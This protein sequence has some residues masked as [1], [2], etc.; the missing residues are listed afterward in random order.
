LKGHQ[1]AILS[2]AFAPDGFHVASAG[3]ST[4]RLAATSLLSQEGA[5][6]ALGGSGDVRM[7]DLNHPDQTAVSFKG[8]QD[9]V[10]A[11][12]FSP[13]SSRL[14]SAGADG[15]VR[16]F[17]PKD[18][19]RTSVILNERRLIEAR[20]QYKTMLL[21]RV[22]RLGVGNDEAVQLQK[23]IAAIGKGHSS[24]FTV[25]LSSDLQW[26]ATVGIERRIVRLWNLKNPED[27]PLVLEGRVSNL[28]AL[29]FSPDATRLASV[30]T[31]IDTTVQVWD[32][33]HPG[34]PRVSG[35]QGTATAVAFS[36]DSTR[37]ALGSFS[38]QSVTVKL[39]D[40]KATE[41]PLSLR[42]QGSRAID[43][44]AFSNDGSRVAGL[45]RSTGRVVIWN[46]WSRTADYLCT[47]VWRNLSIDEW[48]LYVGESIPYERTCPA[49]PSGP[50]VDRK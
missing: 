6:L 23:A 38:G 11:V 17:S 37:L 29:A 41:P 18:P 7:W 28:T 49:L 25:A 44:L 12:G 3:S 9:A 16:E 32:L 15:T 35:T 33:R 46:L 1:D 21:D 47:R 19:G 24:F 22:R 5:R 42:G 48:R 20:E 34:A 10:I 2:V 40:L 45:E 36:P 31:G 13:D 50:G 27:S 8:N 43:S 30:A 4:V 39:W 14:R 26:L